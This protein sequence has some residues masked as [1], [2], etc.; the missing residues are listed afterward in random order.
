[1]IRMKRFLKKYYIN[2]IF[3]IPLVLY[4]LGFTLVPIVKTILLGFHDQYT[5]NWS[6][7][8][9][10]YLFGKA[11]FNRAIFNTVFVTLVGLIIQLGI[12]LLIALALRNKF[13]GEGIVRAFVLLPM[14]IPTIVSG[15]ALTYIFG[16]S[17]YFN[18]LLYK[19]GLIGVP[20]NWT[21]KGLRCLFVVAFADS[22]KVLPMIVLLLL[23]GLKS[24]SADIYEASSIDGAT[25]WQN[26]VHI[27][28][29]MLKPTI[30]MTVLMRAVDSFR[31]FELPKVLVGEV[32]P[33]LSTY[34]YDE[35]AYNNLS[36][37]G[38]ASTILLIIII[39]F[40]VLYLKYVDK[41]EGLNN[42]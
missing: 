9:Y 27:T 1:M 4:I 21:A 17:G 37:S 7:S 25:K 26:F 28:L 24:I 8:S 30:T 16:T 36:F 32:A 41:G 10:A 29:P 6:L 11:D 15:V 38:A 34:A 12:G 31:I 39:T 23:A 35:Y 2:I 19:L 3:V 5:G 18:E 20:I 22:W 42:A 13:K 33:F 14:G 40:S